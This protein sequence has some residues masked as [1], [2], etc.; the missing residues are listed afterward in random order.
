M[1]VTDHT[2]LNPSFLDTNVKGRDAAG[3]ATLG[4]GLGLGL[5]V[6]AEGAK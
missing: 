4:L 6:F 1:N 2:F 5:G 3:G